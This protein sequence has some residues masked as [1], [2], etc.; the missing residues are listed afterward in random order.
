MEDGSFTNHVYTFFDPPW[1]TRRGV[2]AGVAGVALATPVFGELLRQKLQKGKISKIFTYKATPVSESYVRPCYV[3]DPQI[4][5]NTK[6]W[7]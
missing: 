3:N 7:V 5:I 4:Q 6:V 1:L 2:F